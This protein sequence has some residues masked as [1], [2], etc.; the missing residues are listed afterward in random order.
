MDKIVAY[1]SMSLPFSGQRIIVTI[2]TKFLELENLNESKLDDVEKIT[3]HIEPGILL[4]WRYHDW[5]SWYF[6]CF[7][8]TWRF[9]YYN[10]KND[11]FQQY[12]RILESSFLWFPKT[13]AWR[14]KNIRMIFLK[15][16]KLLLTMWFCSLKT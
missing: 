8:N 4:K 11:R 13:T 12:R 1:E 9:F 10:V 3:W 15:A 7:V 5:W 14:L 16:Y 2:W 6:D